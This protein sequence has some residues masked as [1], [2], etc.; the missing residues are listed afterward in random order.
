MAGEIYNVFL[1]GDKLKFPWENWMDNG[2]SDPQQWTTYAAHL[3]RTNFT[4]PW[5]FDRFSDVWNKWFEESGITDLEVGQGFGANLLA[6]GSELKYLVVHVKKALPGTK[7][8]VQLLGTTGNEPADLSKLE[9]AIEDARKAYESAV[10]EANVAP[11]DA[12]KKK[13][14]TKAKADVQKAEDEMAKATATLIQ[15]HSVDFT[16][17][18]FY[19]FQIGEFLQTNGKV[20]VILEEGTLANACFSVMVEVNNFDDQHGCSCGVLPCE[21]EYPDP[22]CQPANI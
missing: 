9:K 13:A 14:V 3:K 1:G 7:V 11:E 18:G 19:R 12:A 20:D 8:K 5:H 4:V 10:A 16:N 6:A 17:A 2:V 22:L 21:T 15:E